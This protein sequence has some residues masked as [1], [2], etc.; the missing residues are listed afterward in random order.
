[1]V[2]MSWMQQARASWRHDISSWVACLIAA[3]LLTDL[4]HFSIHLASMRIHGSVPDMP[5]PTA[6]RTHQFR[7]DPRAIIGAHLF[8][9]SAD[10]APE[11]ARARV[12]LALSGVIAMDDPA[13]GYAILGEKGQ[14]RVY[15]VGSP[16]TGPVAG[17]L[18]QVL[19][20][21]VIVAVDGGIQTLRLP[22]ELSSPHAALVQFAMTDSGRTDDGA[23]SDDA[24]AAAA[25]QAARLARMDS[26]PSDKQKWLAVVSADPDS[27]TSHGIAVHPNRHYERQYGLHDGDVVTAINGVSIT[28]A[29][30]LDAALRNST[31]TMSLTFTHDGTPQTTSVAV[32]P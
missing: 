15:R 1:M 24:D 31:A 19:D 29:D 9:V 4:A 14:M 23:R 27:V 30:A 5:Y 25:A 16:L 6:V 7:I 11:T 13:D 22:R 8:G 17:H 26:I 32:G 12:A 20:D 28:D 18:A 21:R 3:A 2:R 10:N